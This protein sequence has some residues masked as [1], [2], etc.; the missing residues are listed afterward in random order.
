LPRRKPPKLRQES[1]RKKWRNRRRLTGAFPKAHRPVVPCPQGRKALRSLAPAGSS[2][3]TRSLSLG[4]KRSACIC[5]TP[6]NSSGS[7]WVY[8]SVMRVD[9][10]PVTACTFCTSNP[11]FCSS[12]LQKC[13]HACRFSPLSAIST[14]RKP[15][16]RKAFLKP[17][18]TYLR[19]TGFTP[20]SR[21]N[22]YPSPFIFL[23]R[24]KS[25]ISSRVIGIWCLTLVFVSR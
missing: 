7:K 14:S 5:G 2:A 22:K 17:L 15:I 16:F 11:A 23:S 13:L 4:R 24:R 25:A 19:L 21:E 9:L 1:R 3:I 6:P 10:C 12:V 20:P 18:Y 8:H